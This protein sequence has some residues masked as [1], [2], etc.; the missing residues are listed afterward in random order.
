M[1]KGGRLIVV[2]LQQSEFFNLII[3]SWEGKDPNVVGDM[4]RVDVHN[5]SWK[6]CGCSRER[7]LHR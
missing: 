1:L 5:R 6:V 2:K 3:Q 4:T 7:A